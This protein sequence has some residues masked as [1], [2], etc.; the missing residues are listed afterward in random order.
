MTAL[1]LL[2]PSSQLQECK[3]EASVHFPNETGGTLLGNWLDGNTA[4]AHTIV[5]PGPNAIRGRTFFEPDQEWQLERIADLYF[6]SN[7]KLSYLGDW[8]SHPET[9]IAQP[10]IADR[11]AIKKIIQS[12]EAR[13][14]RPIMVIFCGTPTNWAYFA[15][16]G[17]ISK[18]F[19]I[20]P[21]V[22]VVPMNLTIE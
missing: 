8:H 18:V 10:S 2:L 7:R 21:T 13:C 14:P 17:Y 5:P 3:T 20:I 15:F 12:P 9:N 16:C 11:K 6:A 1:R 22:Q 4:R 19:C